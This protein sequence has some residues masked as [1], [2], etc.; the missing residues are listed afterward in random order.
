M[1]HI[2]YGDINPC[3]EIPIPNTNNELRMLLDER[4]RNGACMQFFG[5]SSYEEVLE[6]VKDKYPERFI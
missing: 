3:K 5:G 6:L 1:T 4:L 2:P